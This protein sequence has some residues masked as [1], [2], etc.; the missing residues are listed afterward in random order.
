MFPI[1]NKIKDNENN[2]L[3]NIYLKNDVHFTPRGNK[4]FAEEIIKKAF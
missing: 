4:L 1:F 3:E 2:W